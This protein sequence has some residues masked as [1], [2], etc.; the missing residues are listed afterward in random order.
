MYS[1]QDIADYYDQT[2]T[3]FVQS[4]NLNGSGALHYGLWFDD[5]LDFAHSLQQTSLYAAK[6]AQLKEGDRLLDAG[7][8]EGGTSILLAQALGCE[9][10]GITLSDRQVK[11]ANHGADIVGANAS[12]SKQ[13]YVN[14]NFPD[15]H[16]DAV[17]AIE[18]FS[19][20]RDSA[21]FFVEMN[22]VLKPGGR[23]VVFDFFKRQDKPIGELKSLQTFLN[24]W[25]I[26]DVETESS[27]KNLLIQNHFSLSDHED[28]SQ[29]IMPSAKRMYRFGLLGAVG[30]KG[31]N[32]VKKATPWSQI[33]YKSGIHQWKSLKRG[34]WYYGIFTAE[35]E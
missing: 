18:S 1:E 23:L 3:H 24:C 28:V 9:A 8:G 5:T 30:T 33:H 20:A 22:R 27:M 17:V 11:A 15:K 13:S 16:F 6:L 12:F 4:W 34:E 26:D 14:T 21:A 10:H 32:L 29:R 7:C 25:A 35:K 31:Y 2:R 19:S